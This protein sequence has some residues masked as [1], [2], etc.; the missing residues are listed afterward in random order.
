MTNDKR[1]KKIASDEKTGQLTIFKV[2]AFVVLLLVAGGLMFVAGRMS[3][4]SR[5]ENTSTAK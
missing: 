3:G 1:V 2:V 5:P 4:H